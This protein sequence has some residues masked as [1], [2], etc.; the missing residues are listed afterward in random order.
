M[1][2]DHKEICE[3]LSH[4]E[5]LPGVGP[6]IEK[7]RALIESQ[8]ARIAALEAKS[9]LLAASLDQEERRVASLEAQLRE[10]GEPVKYQW[11]DP[12][13]NWIDLLDGSIFRRLKTQ[14]LAVRKLY[15]HP[16]AAATITL[17]DDPQ[18]D[19]SRVIR[20][21]AGE[22]EVA[23]MCLPAAA[24]SNAPTVAWRVASQNPPGGYVIFQQR[25]EYFYE[26]HADRVE[27]LCVRSG[28]AAESE[29]AALLRKIPTSPEQVIE[30]IGS[31]FICMRPTG[32]DG[33][34]IGDM[35]N[36]SYTLTVHDLLSA[37][38]WSDLSAER[39]ADALTAKEKGE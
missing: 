19:G 29:A 25:P 34:P 13:G 1:T 38:A 2:T 37:F 14:G 10:R 3:R 9:A 33:N 39:I 15:V 8:A 36:V 20:A 7:A 24:E 31:H 6:L 18:P 17:R 16:P 4:A 26:H 22:D 30:F 5:G 28:A 11:R 12:N 32:E 23:R 35:L 21:M 27:E